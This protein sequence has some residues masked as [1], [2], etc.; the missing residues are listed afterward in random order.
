M[1]WAVAA[2]AVLAIA[3]SA[4]PANAQGT[5]F[6]DASP[7]VLGPPPNPQAR[8]GQNNPP[9]GFAVGFT[10][11]GGAL[12]PPSNVGQIP[13]NPRPHF[14]NP[15]FEGEEREEVSLKFPEH[16]EALNVGELTSVFNPQPH[17]EP[18]DFEGKE[19]TSSNLPKDEE[20]TAK[21]EDEIGDTQ[22][23]DD[24]PLT[25]P[26][27]SDTHTPAPASPREEQHPPPPP[28]K[29]PAT[30]NLPPV[31][32]VTP[33]QE[34]EL[35]LKAPSRDNTN[36]DQDDQNDHYT[37]TLN[38]Q[39]HFEATQDVLDVVSAPRPPRSPQPARPRP[40]PEIP[41]RRTV[42]PNQLPTYSGGSDVH[43]LEAQG[44]RE[45]QYR[46]NYEYEDELP[47]GRYQGEEKEDE[48]EEEEPDRLSLL[49]LD[50]KF[51]CYERK[52]G[53]YADEELECEVFHYCQDNVKHS[54]L[55]PEGASFH[56]VHL[57]C[58]PRSA[59]NICARSSKFH[60]VNDF[61]YKELEGSDGRNKTYADRYYPEGFANGVSGAGGGLGAVDVGVVGGGGGSGGGGGGGGDY[62][63][64]YSSGGGGGGGGGFG[65]GG[66]YSGGGGF[67]RGGGGG[68]QVSPRPRRPPPPQSPQPQPLPSYLDAIARQQQQQ[69]QQQQDQS[70]YQQQR[71]EQHVPPPQPRPVQ[72]YEEPQIY[73]EEEHKEE[74]EPFYSEPQ[75]SH[76]PPPSPQHYQP[77]QL[78]PL[79]PP[80]PQRGD[81]R[82]PPQQ[83][84]RPPPPQHPPRRFR[85]RTDG[86]VGPGQY[87]GGRARSFEEART[88]RREY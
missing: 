1:R 60:F 66:G 84:A 9:R 63:G 48:E 49:L 16:E 25:S 64:G 79:P 82:P 52:N 30:F 41:Y 85:G 77:Q 69:Q 44:S 58:M 32:E 34:E 35:Q 87:Q 56:Q 17:F 83:F 7:F 76:P 80:P 11:S 81:F 18:F 47:G 70:P 31:P 36:H 2:A 75:I 55:C 13:L 71:Q 15:K 46:V 73:K 40:Y 57:I 88:Q 20:Q 59:E 27:S 42:H 65:G 28:S 68:G 37:Q 72:Q 29:T 22:P 62:D 6:L 19:E 86:G 26:D 10:Q 12:R 78:S 3:S 14:D 45:Q 61:L 50:S 21:F 51:A 33:Q 5:Q 74:E 43:D 24:F 38:P 53:Y 54:W 39:H 67:G 4:L 8:R 23:L